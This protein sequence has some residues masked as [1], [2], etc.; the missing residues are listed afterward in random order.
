M[1]LF[2]DR[3]LDGISSLI[4]NKIPPPLPF[5]SKQKEKLHPFNK[6]FLGEK[7]SSSFVSDIISILMFPFT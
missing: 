7:L 1:F 2:I 6:N 4:Y 3:S 5:L